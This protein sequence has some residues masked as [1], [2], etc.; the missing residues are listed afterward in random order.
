MNGM[1]TFAARVI[2]CQRSLH[3]FLDLT[4]EERIRE[5]GPLIGTYRVVSASWNTQ[6]LLIHRFTCVPAFYL[7]KATVNEVFTQQW[8]L[9]DS[10]CLL[11]MDDAMG[12]PL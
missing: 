10:D 4:P 7:L 2:L 9:K 8:G 11:D 3:G 1:N 5:F 6:M 12:A